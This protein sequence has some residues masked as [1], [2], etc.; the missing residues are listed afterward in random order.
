M[1]IVIRKCPSLAFM[2]EAP[3]SQGPS[4]DEVSGQ[5]P[6]EPVDKVR[7]NMVSSVNGGSRGESCVVLE[8]RSVRSIYAMERREELSP[9]GL[10][11]VNTHVW[12]LGQS[13]DKP[14]G[15]QV[16]PLRKQFMSETIMPKSSKRL[17]AMSRHF[18][19]I[20]RLGTSTS[21]LLY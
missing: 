7:K 10:S 3:S 19:R 18:I 6:Q 4:G 17:S 12:K 1:M 8:L 15:R 16:L 9:V 21:G 2:A 5:L 11:G 20:L 13:Q 14:Y